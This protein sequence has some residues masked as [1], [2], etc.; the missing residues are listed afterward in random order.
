MSTN[1][2]VARVLYRALYRAGKQ[3]MKVQEASGEPM[4]SPH[5]L[6][7]LA[8]RSAKLRFGPQTK[9][10]KDVGGLQAIK[11]CDDFLSKCKVDGEAK[12]AHQLGLQGLR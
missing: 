5:L 11:G 6:Q 9:W 1:A 2:R 8:L 4:E 3:W 7:D 10:M 12:P